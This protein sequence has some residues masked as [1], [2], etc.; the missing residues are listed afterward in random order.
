MEKPVS[1][2][3]ELR[4]LQFLDNAAT[5]INKHSLFTDLEQRT[6]TSL[7]RLASA[8]S[9]LANRGALPRLPASPPTPPWREFVP[10]TTLH[11]PGLRK[12]SESSPLVARNAAENL[13]SDVYYT[14]TLV[15]TDGFI[16]HRSES[17]TSAYYIPS[18]NMAWQ[19]KS[20]RHPISSTT[21]EL[22]ALLYAAAAVQVTGIAKAV[23]LTDS[24]SALSNVMNSM[25]GSIL[26]RCIRRSCAQHRLTGGELTLQWTPSPVGIRGNER[27]DQLASSAHHSCSPSLPVPADTDRHMAVKQLVEVRHHGIEDIIQN[28]R[29]SLPTKELPRVMQTMFHRIRT[30]YA[31]TNSQ[32]FKIGSREDSSC[33]HCNHPET[34]AHILTFLLSHVLQA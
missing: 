12:K 21:A 31:F 10:A 2:H 13:I 32:P 22:L 30:G 16:D 8:T 5:S 18:M 28:H 14:H 24:R 26:A 3:S 1:V 19:G 29:P 33:G 9:S 7:G 4:G 17:A 27:A 23:L 11:I 34:I 6:H 15:F 25:C 20:V